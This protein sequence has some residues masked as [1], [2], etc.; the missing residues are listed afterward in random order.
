M[1]GSGWVTDRPPSVFARTP[2]PPYYAVIFSSILRGDDPA[3]QR[4]ARRM[5]E[6]VVRQPGFLGFET[7]RSPGELGITVSFWDSLEAIA[8]WKA[9]SEHQIAQRRG[10][11]HWYAGY[12]IRVARVEQVRGFS[13]GNESGPAGGTP[14]RR[15]PPGGR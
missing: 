6:W 15:D 1:P 9:E 5:E 14:M 13:P 3:Y 12:V 8:L 7:A 11:E 4:M 10:R 2:E